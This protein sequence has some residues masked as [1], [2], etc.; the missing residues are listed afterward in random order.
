M[1]RR[2]RELLFLLVVAGAIFL[3]DQ[4][5]KAL[6][7]RNLGFGQSWNPIAPLRPFVNITLIAN[8]G[9]AF[10]LIPGGGLFF[11]V[12]AAVVAAFILTYYRSLPAEAILLKWA[13]G[14]E[15]GGAL[16]NLADRLRYGYV[17]D[18]INFN[19]WPVFN[20]ADGCIT[21]GMVLIGYYFLRS[22]RE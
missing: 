7:L 5:S 20:L 13:L 9:A 2:T 1:W 17:L 16:G 15:L 18:F 14:L 21:L 22:Q 10:G 11:T 4:A 12:V 19:F 8:T 3:A 6:V